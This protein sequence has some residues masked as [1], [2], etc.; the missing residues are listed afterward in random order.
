MACYAVIDSPLMVSE[1]V[2]AVALLSLLSRI[3]LK[4]GVGNVMIAHSVLR[5]PAH[6]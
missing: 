3:G 1:F 6:N 5:E 2:T 4:L